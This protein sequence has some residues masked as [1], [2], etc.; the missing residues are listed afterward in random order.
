MLDEADTHLRLSARTLRSRT[1]D[2]VMQE[3]YALLLTH[4]LLRLLMLRAAGQRD[5]APSRISFTATIRLIDESLV[6]LSLVNASRRAQ[7]V[8]G[9]LK[10]M[11][12]FVLPKQR[13]RIQARVV[14]RVR[15]RYERKKPE[16]WM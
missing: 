3:L 14:K 10:E 13:I 12:T 15:S 16:N 2:G 7:M 4:T 6:P 11:T 5:L 9:L 8:G 1:A